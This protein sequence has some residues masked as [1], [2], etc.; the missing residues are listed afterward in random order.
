MRYRPPNNDLDDPPP[1]ATPRAIRYSHGGNSMDNRALNRSRGEYNAAVGQSFE[2]NAVSVWLLELVGTPN[3]L[4]RSTDGEDVIVLTPQGELRRQVKETSLPTWSSAAMRRYFQYVS[5]NYNGID[6]P[7]FEFYT[8]ATFSADVVDPVEQMRVKGTARR[9]GVESYH[10]SPSVFGPSESLASVLAERVRL[11]P[12][13]ASADE[14]GQFELL[15]KRIRLVIA[16]LAGD[17]SVGTI[18][19]DDEIEVAAYGLLGLSEAARTRAMTSID[20]DRALRLTYTAARYATPHHAY[21]L[22][23]WDSYIDALHSAGTDDSVA[24]HEFTTGKALDRF[25]SS[26]CSHLKEAIVQWLDRVVGTAPATRTTLTSMVIRG[27]RG[28]GKTWLLYEIGRYI[29]AEY[30]SRIAVYVAG[31]GSFTHGGPDPSETRSAVWLVDDA[32]E[33]GW[34]RYVPGLAQRSMVSVLTI[35]TATPLDD[36]E[37]ERTAKRTGTFVIL[38]LPDLITDKELSALAVQRNLPLSVSESE[39]ASRAT[40]RTAARIVRSTIAIRSEVSTISAL[41]DDPKKGRFLRPLLAASVVGLRIPQTLLLRVIGTESKITTKMPEW[42][43]PWIAVTRRPGAQLVFAAPYDAPEAFRRGI[44]N[45]DVVLV[46]ELTNLVAG[47][48]VGGTE[49]NEEQRAERIF[50]RQA[51]SVIARRNR[52]GVGAVLA[53]CRPAIMSCLHTDPLAV[54][55]YNW[56]PLIRSDYGLVKLAA[57]RLPRVL[58][59]VDEALLFIEVYG[60]SLA[61][62]WLNRRLDRLVET[63]VRYVAE[64]TALLLGIQ[65]RLATEPARHLIRFLLELPAKAFRHFMDTGQCGADAAALVG[66]FGTPEARELF[67]ER[68]IAWVDSRWSIDGIWNSLVL[69]NAL[70]LAGRVIMQHRSALSVR[71]VAA[72]VR[73]KPIDW[74]PLAYEECR[75]LDDR[76]AI[77]Q[78]PVTLALNVGV[79]TVEERER[80]R[81]VI[82][83]LLRFGASWLFDD[84]FEPIVELFFELFEPLDPAV[85][86]VRRFVPALD[87]TQTLARS[88]EVERQRLL[89]LYLKWVPRREYNWSTHATVRLVL[90]LIRLAL[91]TQQ[92]AQAAQAAIAAIVNGGREEAVVEFLMELA[93]IAEVDLPEDVWS[94]FPAD[95][96]EDDRSI[97]VDTYLVISKRAGLKGTQATQFASRIIHLWAETYRLRAY[98]AQ[99]CIANGA[100]E[101]AEA[102]LSQPD[103]RPTADSYLLRATLA[104]RMGEVRYDLLESARKAGQSRGIGAHP[105]LIFEAH[106]A[107]AKIAYRRE[108]HRAIVELVRARPLPPWST[109]I[110]TPVDDGQARLEEPIAEPD[111][112]LV[113][114][115]EDNATNV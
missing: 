112:G 37:I 22:T 2:G 46:D 51:L 72:I 47:I 86:P 10:P 41:L 87:A 50:L 65:R 74:L 83:K 28:S 11:F 19:P 24:H 115:A 38:N 12:R 93:A 92:A 31:D 111:N 90:E 33:R 54:V 107:L 68:F 70:D 39:L 84:L 78:K 21:K 91:V 73:G 113:D 34:F 110:A 77:K 49:P 45:P 96:E 42:L 13:F 85:V 53:T 97:G 40:I 55:V 61:R 18:V 63:D 99:S 101:Q 43:L 60:S 26:L 67:L 71:I 76:L 35:A 58:R 105:W 7:T 81:P 75:A 69:A 6:G 17:A 102:F 106:Q 114:D 98:V 66:R 27:I 64:L 5:E 100:F 20:V 16:T 9:G 108:A 52:A 109:V 62:K 48:F 103:T 57:D 29:A 94:G 4:V 25:N 80:L 89:R 59:S 32:F 36:A 79:G 1:S 14:R 3:R 8:N 82:P 56:L 15:K 23:A 88:S 104:A 44:A 95:W 30:S